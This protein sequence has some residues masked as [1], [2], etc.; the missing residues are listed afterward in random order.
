[1]RAEFEEGDL[2]SFSVV[3]GYCKII[4]PAPGARKQEVLV[5]EKEG[6][7]TVYTECGSIGE[8]QMSAVNTLNDT[9]D[10]AQLSCIDDGAG[11][12][13][14][15]TSEWHGEVDYSALKGQVVKLAHYADDIER[16]LTGED[17]I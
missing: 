2:I 16:Q 13:V 3:D 4:L 10:F 7:L 12:K 11:L 17:N 9:M 15:M 6:A 5:Y 14:T 1:L 8:D